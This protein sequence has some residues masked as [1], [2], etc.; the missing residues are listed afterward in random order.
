MAD[1]STAT[2]TQ[3]S[4]AFDWGSVVCPSQIFQKFKEWSYKDPQVL[5]LASGNP[6]FEKFLEIVDKDLASEKPHFRELI[7]GHPLPMATWLHVVVMIG[8]RLIV[9]SIIVLMA[10][11]VDFRGYN[12]FICKACNQNVDEMFRTNPC[13]AY[14]QHTLR[15][16]CPMNMLSACPGHLSYESIRLIPKI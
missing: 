5:E 1:Q 7:P 4:E 12:D 11:F 9:C 14:Q 8:G 3:I 15:T 6:V 2:V 10:K 13:D 16:S